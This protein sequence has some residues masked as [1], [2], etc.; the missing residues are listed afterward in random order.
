[1]HFLEVKNYT[2]TDMV[3]GDDKLARQ[4]ISLDA[5]A[6]MD[7]VEC[8]KHLGTEETLY[9]VVCRTTDGRTHMLFAISNVVNSVF[10]ESNVSAFNSYEDIFLFLNRIIDYTLTILDGRNVKLEYVITID[11]ETGRPL[12][13]VISKAMRTGMGAGTEE[14]MLIVDSKNPGNY[15]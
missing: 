2:I 10:T 8:R 6:S 7:L 1:M 5:I 3:R 4:T 13:Q 14:R 12:Y 9:T 15:Q 11:E